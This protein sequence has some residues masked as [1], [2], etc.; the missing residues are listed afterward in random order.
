MTYLTTLGILTAYFGV[1][2]VVAMVWKRSS[3]NDEPQ[4]PNGGRHTQKESM[5]FSDF[6]A[7][8]PRRPVGTAETS[9]A[10]AKRRA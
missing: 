9:F 1:V 3:R 2:F 7:T 10:N 4:P 5:T 8:Q 6:H